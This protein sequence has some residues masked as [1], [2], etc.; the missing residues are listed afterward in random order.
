MSSD[1][2]GLR[3]SDISLICLA[4]MLARNLWMIVA[5]ALILGMSTSLY[6]TWFHKPVYRA[7]MTYAVTAR[8]TT[9]G[10]N[11]NVSASR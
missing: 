8:R 10:G 6:L 7:T 1:R 3:L 4:R 9:Y 2:N 5:A 11:N